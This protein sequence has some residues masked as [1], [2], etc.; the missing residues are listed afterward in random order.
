MI[1]EKT[2]KNWLNR[3]LGD[4]E[5]LLLSLLILLGLAVIWFLGEALAPFLVSLVVAYILQGPMRMLVER[6]MPAIWA[7]TLT[8]LFFIGSLIG[9]M[10]FLV[11][12]IASE[13][14]AALD[15]LPAIIGYGE[16]MLT[17]LTE[18]TSGHG[19]IGADTLSAL[20]T[21]LNQAALAAGER[22]LA[23][24]LGQIPGLLTLTIYGALVLIL[25][26]FLLKDWQLFG[27][28]IRRTLPTRG[29]AMR[30]IWAEMDR[31]FA[32]YL[33]GKVLEIL[34]VGG[35]AYIIFALFG[36]RYSLMLA[37]LVGLSV[38]IPFIG[39]FAVTIPVVLVALFQ[40]GP[41]PTTFWLVTA[42]VILQI[43]DGNVLV[44]ILFSEAVSLHP[45]VIILAILVFGSIWG[46]WGIFFAIPLATL[47]KALIFA[48]PVA[49]IEH[50]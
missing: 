45:V 6:G 29:G 25:V 18:A 47:I 50:P 4:E 33:R 39:A 31:Q 13:L 20:G 22:F 26:F 3:Y 49:R 5:A 14:K 28:A 23:Y 24:S 10:V 1:A 44:P 7:L 48:W 42:Y 9:S 37:V 19:F 38:L 17:R 46:I 40:W 35:A 41:G 16:Q 30:T 43:L 21:Q 32:N 34:I 12:V 15:D 36:L 8:Y 2:L 27:R 11:P